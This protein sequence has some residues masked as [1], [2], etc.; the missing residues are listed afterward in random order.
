[1]A[2]GLVGTAA[3]GVMLDKLVGH[4]ADD[5]TTASLIMVLNSPSGP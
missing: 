4:V 2:N 3:G 5:V 1:M